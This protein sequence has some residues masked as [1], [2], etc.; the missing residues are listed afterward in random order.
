MKDGERGDNHHYLLIA[1]IESLLV[2]ALLII[3]KINNV[4]KVVS[5]FRSNQNPNLKPNPDPNLNPNPNHKQSPNPNPTL[6]P[7]SKNL[8]IVTALKS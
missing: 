5:I 4:L 8:K 6:Y 3:Y 7:S 2:D 1:I